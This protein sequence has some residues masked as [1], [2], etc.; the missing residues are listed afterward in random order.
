MTEFLVRGTASQ[1][2]PAECVSVPLTAE[3]QESKS[4]VAHEKAVSLQ[5]EIISAVRELEASGS[6]RKWSSDRVRSRSYRPTDHDGRL[7]PPVYRTSIS[8]SVEFTD[9]DALAPFMDAWGAREGV[10]IDELQWAVLRENRERYHADVRADAVRN[11]IA[12][13]QSYA[14]AVDAGTVRALILA[15]PGMLSPGAPTG[16]PVTRSAMFAAPAGPAL[17]IRSGGVEISVS[18]DAQFVAGE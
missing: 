5:S 17:E 13:A 1:I 9:F 10:Q 3:F 16:G 4:V 6:V 8:V 2:Y 18:V 7:Q 15:D 11:A 12:K 14:D